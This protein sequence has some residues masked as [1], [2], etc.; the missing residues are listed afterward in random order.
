MALMPGADCFILGF[1]DA[2]F[3]FTDAAAAA[4]A[5]SGRFARPPIMIRL[6]ALHG[7]S[8]RV[9]G[10]AVGLVA[11]RV[12]VPT[13]FDAGLVG[14][15]VGSVGIP[16]VA[17][18]RSVGIRSMVA[19]ALDGV[20]APA[21]DVHIMAAVVD[22]KA[23]K[24]A[25]AE[26]APG[27]S[28]RGSVAGLGPLLHRVPRKALRDAAARKELEQTRRD[29]V[30]QRKALDSQAAPLMEKELAL[31][32]MEQAL[33]ETRARMEELRQ[34]DADDRARYS[35]VLEERGAA[36]DAREQRLRERENTDASLLRAL[37]EDEPDAEQDAR[38]QQQAEARASDLQIASLEKTVRDR[39]QVI[40]E[41][42]QAMA[43]QTAKIA[44]QEAALE[45]QR[46]EYQE[47]E[48]TSFQKLAELQQ[49]NRASEKLQKAH[50]KRQEE[51]RHQLR[52]DEHDSG[53]QQEHRRGR[54]AADAGQS[55]SGV[56]EP[57]SVAALRERVADL[58]QA[59][60]EALE[61]VA[62]SPGKQDRIVVAPTLTKVATLGTV[63]VNPGKAGL[64]TTRTEYTRIIPAPSPSDAATGPP[65]AGASVKSQTRDKRTAVSLPQEQ[66]AEPARVRLAGSS[67][68]ASRA[69]AGS[70]SAVSLPLR[71][72]PPT[73][74]FFQS[75]IG[76][77][78][79]GSSGGCGWMPSSSKSGSRSVEVRTVPDPR[80]GAGGPGRG[81]SHSAQPD[82]ELL[83][84]PTVFPPAG[85]PI[86]SAA[87]GVPTHDVLDD[88]SGPGAALIQCGS[89]GHGAGLAALARMHQMNISA[90]SSC[91]IESLFEAR[92]PLRPHSARSVGPFARSRG[93]MSIDAT[94]GDQGSLSARST[95]A[96]TRVRKTIRSTFPVASVPVAVP[97]R[98]ISPA[99]PR[100]R[101]ETPPG[102]YWAPSGTR[103]LTKIREKKSA[104][105]SRSPGTG[106]DVHNS[107]SS[108]ATASAVVEVDGDERSAL[109]REQEAVGGGEE[110]SQNLVNLDAGAGAAGGP[111]AA[112]TS[113]SR[114]S[115]KSFV[116]PKAPTPTTRSCVNNPFKNNNN[117]AMNMNYANAKQVDQ[118]QE[119]DENE[120][121]ASSAT[122]ASVVVVM[123][124]S[125]SNESYAELARAQSA[126]SGRTP[127]F[128]A[129]MA[130]ADDNPP[131]IMTPLKE[132]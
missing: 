28:F 58:Q 8:T 96:R 63:D 6:V 97:I 34:Q 71:V 129:D 131:T 93:G 27:C 104:T 79:L 9:V 121:S 94:G 32:A 13:E 29:I 57:R 119:H 89:D 64:S 125:A 76:V 84:Q 23:L 132:I 111:G 120:N 15:T 118:Q 36:I 18:P 108:S 4:G 11:S 5:R 78:G 50:R 101:S 127:I 106:G 114:T 22:S 85:A 52:D 55:T 35:A 10:R 7:G 40:A 87:D 113:S 42:E 12:K 65:T 70:A 25:D 37:P 110:P 43:Q 59:L 26:T 74:S 73:A 126:A 2:A 31:R 53:E 117:A 60:Q 48:V 44:E 24:R 67:G 82:G 124:R 102:L 77:G 69:R 107:Y 112:S 19:R 116:P 33:S 90:S 51:S 41:Q 17:F 99:W 128:P 81:S 39:E 98:P 100:A 75:R 95:P 103:N 66:E 16:V 14:R 1:E 56:A 122:S 68:H 61:T 109:T 47:Y 45:A 38:N 91:S 88:E 123:E 54:R 3:F 80:G 21:V 86:S 30:E 46:A 49:K 115:S 105:R 130:A 92:L 72:V 20:E 83:L 62:K